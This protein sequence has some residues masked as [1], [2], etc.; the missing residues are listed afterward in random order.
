M[1]KA[2]RY[3]DWAVYRECNALANRLKQEYDLENGCVYRS[4]CEV[5]DDHEWS[6]MYYK[7]LRVVTENNTYEA[8]E[9][10]RDATAGEPFDSLAVHACAVVRELLLQ[11][12]LKELEERGVI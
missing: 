5:C 6:I 4:A 1:S 2:E 9:S 8:E 10:V 12:V 7:A 3:D 11:G